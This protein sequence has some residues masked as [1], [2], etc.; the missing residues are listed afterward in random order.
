MAGSRRRLAEFSPRGPSPTLTVI[1]DVL[2]HPA[3]VDA[4]AWSDGEP[5]WL[6]KRGSRLSPTSMVWSR[7]GVSDSTKCVTPSWR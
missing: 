3:A 4:A 5:S 7:Y 2:L 1:K 6:R